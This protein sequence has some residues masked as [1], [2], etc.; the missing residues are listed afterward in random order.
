SG[1]FPGSYLQMDSLHFITASIVYPDGNIDAL[2]SGID[3]LTQEILWT[4]TFGTELEDVPTRLIADDDQHMFAYYSA[5]LSES[6]FISITNLLKLDTLGNVLW[7]T[8]IGIEDD[9]N[10][11]FNHLHLP[12]GDHLTFYA[13][14]E[15]GVE[16]QSF[17][18]GYGL[19]S[20]KVDSLGNE[21]WSQELRRGHYTRWNGTD[22]VLLDDGLIALN[23]IH[24]TFPLPAD[25]VR[26]Q[27]MLLWIDQ[28][29]EIVREF[30]FPKDR[31]RNIRSMTK[32]ANGDIIGAG[33]VDLGA[34]DLG[35]AGYVF[36]MRPDGTLLW[37][38]YLADVRFPL[39]SHFFNDVIEAEDGGIVL[40][41]LLQDSIPG[42][43]PPLN[44]PN[45]WLVKLDSFGCLEPGCSRFQVMGA[46][47]NIEE[48]V[49]STA[50]LRLFPNPTAT[51][52]QL[53]WPSGTELSYPLQVQVYDLM[54]RPVLQRTFQ[55]DPLVLQCSE[56]V[57]GYYLVQVH[58]REGR[59][60]TGKLVV[61]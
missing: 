52:T 35:R 55:Q 53:Q 40:T 33:S 38:R 13:A 57:A 20:T 27:D 51:F 4:K 8:P 45:V 5:M 30:F 59:Q 24:D 15:P 17:L 7:Q 39:N 18:T 23:W 48:A 25:T 61:W 6:P 37:E 28:D 58:D 32:A 46:T 49:A 12:S 1:T 50:P 60:W 26:F 36:R 19:Y 3:P 16:C 44:N 47:V 9:Y 11:A 10:N 22:P 31:E 42:S 21:L 34:L 41:G 54:G 43:D 14:C 56:W 29:G 2:V